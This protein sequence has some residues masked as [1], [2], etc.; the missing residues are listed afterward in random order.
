MRSCDRLDSTKRVEDEGQDDVNQ[1]QKGANDERDKPSPEDIISSLLS[2]HD[3]QRAFSALIVATVVQSLRSATMPGQRGPVPVPLHDGVRDVTKEILEH[4][5]LKPE[6]ETSS[7]FPQIP[8]N[9]IKSAL[10]RLAS[11][12]MVEY[13]SIDTELVLLTAE[14]QT[15]CEEGSHEWKVWDAVQRNGKIEMKDLQVSSSSRYQSAGSDPR[16]HEQL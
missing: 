11:R 12:S 14:A 9:E 6:L 2:H 16:R 8:Q 5:S 15:I 10:D 3:V 7:E 13:K 4:L 1:R